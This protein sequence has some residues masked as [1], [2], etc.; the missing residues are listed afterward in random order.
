MTL[1]KQIKGIAKPIKTVRG[2]SQVLLLIKF[3][4]ETIQSLKDYWQSNCFKRLSCVD[5]DFGK[6][7]Q[8]IMNV[9]NQLLFIG[10]SAK[11]LKLWWQNERGFAD[12]KQRNQHTR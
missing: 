3:L 12:W 10:S 11:T 9:Q 5:I 6:G 2:T 7:C 4:V 8:E 1:F